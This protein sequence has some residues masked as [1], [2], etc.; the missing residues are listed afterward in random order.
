MSLSCQEAEISVMCLR[1]DVESAKRELIDGR[2]KLKVEE[3]V[4]VFIECYQSIFEEAS[5]IVKCQLDLYIC[6]N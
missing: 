6:M 4:Y 2:H 1:D 3:H 5:W